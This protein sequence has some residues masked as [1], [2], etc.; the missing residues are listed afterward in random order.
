MIAK[1]LKRPTLAM[2]V[3][4]AIGLIVAAI[5]LT[6]AGKTPWQSEI[7]SACALACIGMGLGLLGLSLIRKLLIRGGVVGA[8]AAVMVEETL[9]RR[10]A[11]ICGGLLIVVL[12][13][14]PLL[15]HSNQVLEYR[16]S[17][18]LGYS[19]FS[20][21]FLVSILA[22]FGGCG[23]LCEEFTDRRIQTVLVKPVGRVRF[24][25]GKWLGI[26]AIVSLLLLVSGLVTTGSLHLQLAQARAAG[27]DTSNAERVLVSH[28]SLAP[29]LPEGLVESIP[30]RAERRRA[31]D[32]E[33]WRALL[34]EENGEE[35][36]AM[37]ALQLQI[38]RQSRS[39]WRSVAPGA[40]RTY[41]YR[42]PASGAHSTATLRL[43]PYFG[44]V[45]AT[46][47]TR[48]LIRVDGSEQAVFLG[49]GETQ[50]LEIPTSALSD[51][52][53]IVEIE[54]PQDSQV[55]GRT[56][57]FLGI[58]GQTLQISRGGFAGNLTRGLLIIAIQ[59]AFITILGLSAS[60]FLSLPVSVLLVFLILF[61][62]VGGG[63]FLDEQS[64]LDEPAH[65]HSGHGHSHGPVSVSPFL[66]AVDRLGRS[67]VGVFAAWGEVR[68]IDSISSADEI[69]P[70]TVWRALFSIGGIWA[71]CTALLGAVIFCR[72]EIAR[73]QI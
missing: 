55:V 2:F 67:F 44:R 53:V 52:E 24:L 38:F 41:R 16:L 3:L 37:R 42:I 33:A 30:P 63:F 48:L 28:R 46:E 47:R 68:V 56:A 4:S 40:T 36:V 43:S 65:F 8:V 19:L 22:I 1:L 25:L 10:V 69:A 34:A 61:A 27:V 60:T 17:S 9:R 29:E 35:A 49:G 59:L 32:P 62:A 11:S 71:G 7:Y 51:G 21:M 6:V 58:D 18:F 26:V 23:S 14:I 15:L 54:N 31:E 13:T 73:V 39:Q 66:R 50:V 5:S 12:V 64:P 57:K 20:T 72:R 45:H 70:S